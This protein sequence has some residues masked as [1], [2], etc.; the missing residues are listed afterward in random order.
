[1]KYVLKKE[2]RKEK[3]LR[4][5]GTVSIYSKIFLDVSTQIG[6]HQRELTKNEIPEKLNLNTYGGGAKAIPI[7][8]PQA[9]RFVRRYGSHIF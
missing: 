8:C 9:Q 7:T 5:T 2:K 3:N 4:Y 1:M 6:E